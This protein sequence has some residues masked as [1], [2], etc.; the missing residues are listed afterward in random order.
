MGLDSGVEDEA[1]AALGEAEGGEKWAVAQR[2][3]RMRSGGGSRMRMM[4]ES[5]KLGKNLKWREKWRII[6]KME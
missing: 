3:S 2:R 1:E 5:E 6:E 4:R